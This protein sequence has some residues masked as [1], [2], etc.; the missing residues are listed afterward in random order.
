M[1]EIRELKTVYI[2]VGSKLLWWD[3][4]NTTMKKKPFSVQLTEVELRPADS[5]TGLIPKVIRIRKLRC[6]YVDLAL[7]GSVSILAIVDF[8][9]D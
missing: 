4:R 3:Q 8:S 9:E 5:S 7:K 6:T 1:F 2:D